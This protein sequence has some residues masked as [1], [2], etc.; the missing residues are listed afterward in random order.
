MTILIA[1][2]RRGQPFWSHHFRV[3]PSQWASFYRHVR[4]CRQTSEYARI[5]GL[6]DYVSVL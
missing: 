3:E 6:G 5:D 2:R 4:V 1:Y